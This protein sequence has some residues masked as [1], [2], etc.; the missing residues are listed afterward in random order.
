VIPISSAFDGQSSSAFASIDDDHVL[1]YGG[2][3]DDKVRNTGVIVDL[4]SGATTEVTGPSIHGGLARASAA[5]ETGTRSVAVAGLQ[6]VAPDEDARYLGENSPLDGCSPGPLT[7]AVYDAAKQVWSASRDAPFDYGQAFAPRILGFIAG[8]LY[9]DVSVYDASPHEDY[10]SLDTATGDWTH[11]AAPPGPLS[12]C[13][14]SHRSSD[15]SLTTTENGNT[16]YT[17]PRVASYDPDKNTWSTQPV[18]GLTS[19]DYPFTRSCTEHWIV[20]NDHRVGQSDV[21]EAFSTQDGA[22]VALPAPP[23]HQLLASILVSA[24]D[25]LMTWNAVDVPGADDATPAAISI[26]DQSSWTTKVSPAVIGD[27]STN[28]GLQAYAHA[29]T[30][31]V[32]F[33][34][35]EVLTAD[36]SQLADGATK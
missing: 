35:G 4:R 34:N 30:R 28:V 8:R 17:D 31:V 3:S 13:L 7:V 33:Y 5:T 12:A 32:A 29:G 11:I 19:S 2:I 1:A 16:T 25:T 6:C 36:V 15:S 24:G 18:P 14:G 9:I 10:V 22:W 20:V 27:S 21:Y 23:V 26:G